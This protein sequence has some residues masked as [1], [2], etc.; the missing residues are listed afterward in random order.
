M[1]NSLCMSA[2]SMGLKWMLERS[3]SISSCS[4]FSVWF[5]VLLRSTEAA[6][7]RFENIRSWNRN[8]ETIKS[9]TKGWLGVKLLHILCIP[10]LYFNVARMIFD[11]LFKVGWI[12][13]W[14][15]LER[16]FRPLCMTRGQ[17]EAVFKPWN[18]KEK[19]ERIHLIFQIGLNLDH[20]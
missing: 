1:L 16:I 18:G 11:E 12:H 9:G 13:S 3:V 5:S 17:I 2:G 20:F 10:W 6:S 15:T 7:V 14:D 4:R 8:R 19:K